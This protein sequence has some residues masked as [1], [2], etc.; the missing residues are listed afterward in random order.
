MKKTILVSALCAATAAFTLGGCGAKNDSRLPSSPSEAYGLGAVSTVRLL[1]GALHAGTLTAISDAAAD[2]DIKL[3]AKKFNEYFTALD[4][5]LGED[6]VS[7]QTV[8]NPDSEYPYET[9][10]TI[11]GKE[12]DGQTATY[13]MYYTEKLLHT[14]TDRDE[15][16]TTFSLTGVMAL[17]GKDY[18]LEG[19]RS[20][21][22]E[23]DGRESELKI[24][25][26]ADINDKSTYVQMEHETSTETGETENEYVYSVYSGWKLIEQTAVEFET[27]TK[28][29][30]VETEYE[31]EFI[32]G[33]AKGKYEVSRDAKGGNSE[34]KVEYKIDGK[35]GEFRI[36]EITGA[37][38]EK[39]YEYTFSDGSKVIY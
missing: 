22:T 28:G 38:G 31:L 39:K 27:E 12:L 5:F 18:S 4:S 13:T 32:N 14:Q 17:D 2:S 7:T 6:L 15:T 33:G 11:T 8:A 16:K 30:K 3:Q 26:Y 19:E 25:A 21:E 29:G 20:E 1:G 9:K 23:D 10:M 37:D 34:I 36:R 24:R 35:K